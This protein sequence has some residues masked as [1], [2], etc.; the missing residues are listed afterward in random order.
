MK[1]KKGFTLVELLAV[2]AILAILMLLIMP[3]ILKSYNK[4]RKESFKVQIQSIVKAAETQKQSDMFYS[5]DSNHYC[6]NIGT[7]CRSSNKL[8][9]QDNDV[10]YSVLFEDNKVVG[11]GLSDSNYCY[12]GSDISSI[13]VNDFVDNAILVC[14]ESEC[15]CGHYVYFGR[16]QS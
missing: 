9:I 4:G 5:M 1:N 2:I 3:N 11:V 10:K 7:V 16:N 12:V 8:D 13:D 6:D 15:T 14:D